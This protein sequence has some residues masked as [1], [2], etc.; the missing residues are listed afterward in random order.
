MIY[1]RFIFYTTYIVNSFIFFS[2]GQEVSELG[3]AHF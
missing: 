1:Y 3:L 2:A